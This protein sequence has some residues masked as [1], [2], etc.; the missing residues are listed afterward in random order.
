MSVQIAR[1]CF[2]VAE[3]ERMGEAGIFSADD[4]LELIEGE[5]VEMLPIGSRHAACVKRLSAF[6]NRRLSQAVIISVQDPIVLNDYS[7]PQPDVAL[8]KQRD[9]F[10]E[11]AHPE[12]DDVLLVIEVADTTLEYDRQIKVPLYARSGVPEVWVVNLVDERI[13][14]F[15]R[16]AGGS[17]QVTG[18]VGR[19]ETVRSQ[20]VAGLAVDASD[21]LG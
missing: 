16:P 8:L 21:V 4:R 7:E 12:A 2:T 11:N 19:G 5:I 9:D 17:Y 18:L 14:T 3:Y 13:E 1:H 10:Y 20:T 6:L 15:A